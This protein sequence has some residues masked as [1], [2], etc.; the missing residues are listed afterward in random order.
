MSFS[1]VTRWIIA[2][3]MYVAAV[4]YTKVVPG[5][6]S[7]GQAKKAFTQSPSGA[8][9]TLFVGSSPCPVVMVR[10]C[11]MVRA[12]QRWSNCDGSLSGKK[13]TTRSPMLTRFS[14]CHTNSGCGKALAQGVQA[15][16]E[17]RRKGSTNLPRGRGPCGESSGCGARCSAQLCHLRNQAACDLSLTLDLCRVKLQL[18]R[19]SSPYR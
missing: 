9:M 5:S 12:C 6:W 17:V 1:P 15:V 16:P 19:P 4:L 13:S 7:S 14:S 18:P 11:L 2:E 3:S 10:R 8:P